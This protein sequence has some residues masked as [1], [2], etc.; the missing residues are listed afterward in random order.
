MQGL[1]QTLFERLQGM[2]GDSISEVLTVQ[3]RMHTDIMEWSS[4]ELYQGKLSA[5]ASV[6][7]HT[8]SDMQVSHNLF[9]LF[10]NQKSVTARSV[11]GFKARRWP[12]RYSLQ[13]HTSLQEVSMRAM[14]ACYV[15]AWHSCRA[16]STA[17]VV[18][19]GAEH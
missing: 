19:V 10:N 9:V 17:E 6:A 12:C 16:R 3:Y 11:S 4:Q 2:Y 13:A 15:Q 5:H 18:S 1:S 8:L 7:T 14:M